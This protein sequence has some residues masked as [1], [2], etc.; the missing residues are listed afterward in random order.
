MDTTET[1]EPKKQSLYNINHEYLQRIQLLEEKEFV[2]DPEDEEFLAINKGQLEQKSISYLE[3]IQSKE[4]FTTR[5]D[6]EIKRLQAL[7]KRNER[8]IEAL[9]ENLL[10]AV[11][12][13]GAYEVG[14][15]KFGTRKSKSVI[16]DAT[17]VNQL[18]AEYKVVSVTESANKAEIKKALKKGK[19]IDG[20]S[21]QENLNLKIN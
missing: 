7:K 12:T 16:I 2:L 14:F 10:T 13:F 11:K 19:T 21:I 5:I 9:K 15:T 1:K 6:D 8:T 17:K 20:C 18:P 4:A 3:V